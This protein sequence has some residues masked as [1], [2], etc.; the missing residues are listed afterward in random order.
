MSDKKSFLYEEGH[1]RET[2][3]SYKAYLEEMAVGIKNEDFTGENELVSLFF[4][5]ILLVKKLFAPVMYTGQCGQCVSDKGK[6]ETGLPV[7][8]PKLKNLNFLDA[9]DIK[10]YLWQ[11]LLGR[12]ITKSFVNYMFETR[13]KQKN[14]I[15]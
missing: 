10:F 15:L 4:N 7:Q 1:K 13:S 9:V 8:W 2:R 5:F 6:V 12:C 3:K 14:V 11:F